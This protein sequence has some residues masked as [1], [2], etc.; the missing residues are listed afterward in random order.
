M[1]AAQN[2]MSLIHEDGNQI[3]STEL[4]SELVK[5]SSHHNTAEPKVS[6]K[7]QRFE[8]LLVLINESKEQNDN[9]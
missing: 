1:N 5:N 4:E 9:N 7:I 8:L 2:Q 6:F 3:W